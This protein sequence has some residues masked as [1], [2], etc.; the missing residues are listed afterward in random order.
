ME[1]ALADEN[2]TV[3]TYD[4]GETAENIKITASNRFLQSGDVYEGMT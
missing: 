3:P 4:E 2:D 1:E